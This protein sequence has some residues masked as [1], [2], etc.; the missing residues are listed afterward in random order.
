MSRCRRLS[1]NLAVSSGNSK[2]RRWARCCRAAILSASPMTSSWNTGPQDRRDTRS[3][4]Q[5][6]D[7][8][9]RAAGAGHE[10]AAVLLEG[11]DEGEQ[12]PLPGL[13]AGHP[14]HVVQA[15][16]G[17]TVEVLHR[18]RIQEHRLT[19]GQ[20]HGAPSRRR[21]R[22]EG[23]LQQ[24]R[25]AGAVSTVQEHHRRT[26]LLRKSLQGI[27]SRSVGPGMETLESSAFVESDGQGQL[28]FQHAFRAHG[29]PP[30]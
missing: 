22:A 6:L 1:R 11:I 29:V 30:R 8:G 9:R 2:P 3:G 18:G 7:A 4:K 23:R 19:H 24:M 17:I 26:A 14:L 13:G 20:V 12:R 27:H 25:F 16:Q 21:G 15:H 5:P 28:T 10:A